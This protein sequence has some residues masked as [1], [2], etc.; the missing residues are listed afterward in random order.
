MA[1]KFNKA[2]VV[3]ALRSSFVLLVTGILIVLFTYAALSKLHDYEK[4]LVQLGQSPL[5]TSFAK[6][7]AWFVPAVEIII[8]LLLILP[9]TRL[10][11]LYASFTMM[12]MFSAY[13]VAITRFSP[14]VPCSCGG[15]LEK[16][17]WNQHLVFNIAITLLALL[18]ILV[19]KENK[20]GVQNE[21]QPVLAV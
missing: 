4:F 17:N 1:K 20:G 15:I 19:Y 6:W 12:V 9:G 5:L 2:R 11:A 3:P 14:Y 13:I 21:R 8:A 7:V 16:M 10:R 18:S